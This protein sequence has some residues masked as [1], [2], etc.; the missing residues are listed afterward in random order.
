MIVSEAER[1][2]DASPDHR[3]LRRI[4]EPEKW[5][6]PAG[7]AA[8]RRGLYVDVESTGLSHETDEVIELAIVPFDYDPHSGQIMRVDERAAFC[9]FR[10]PSFPIPAESTEIHLS[11]IHI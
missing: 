8:F 4:P 5:T 6:L 7:D 11:L 2:L 9:G 3:I 1:V 10:Q